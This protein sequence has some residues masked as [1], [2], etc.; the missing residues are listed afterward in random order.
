LALVEVPASG[1]GENVHSGGMDGAQQSLRLI[2]VRIE[3]AVDGGDHA[4]DLEALALG[5]VEGAIG[6]NLDLEPLK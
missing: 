2:A 3:L 5:H 4:F 6:Q 1:V